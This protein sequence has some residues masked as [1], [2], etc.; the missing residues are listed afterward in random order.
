MNRETFAQTYPGR[1]TEQQY[2][3]LP[4]FLAGLADEAIG[5][6]LYTT[7][8]NIGHH[9]SNICRKFDIL[10]EDDPDYR[11][12]LVKLFIQHK[13]ELVSDLVREKYGYINRPRYP[14]GAE[15]LD[16]PY[17]VKRGVELTCSNAL[18]EVGSL[19]RISVPKEMGKTSLLKRLIAE[20]KHKQFHTTYLN[21]SQFEASALTDDIT[22]LKKF[23]AYAAQ[24]LVDVEASSPWNDSLSAMINCTAQFQNL[25]RQLK[26]NLVLVLDE[27]DALFAYPQVY[28]SFFPMLRNWHND[29]VNDSEI[30]EKLR[31][32]IAYSTEDF[33]R[34][35]INQSPFNVGIPI[36]LQNF[37]QDQVQEL[38]LRHG[39]NWQEILPL[40]DLVQ[41]HPYLIRLGF[42]HLANHTLPLRELLEHAPTDDGI[43]KSHLFRLLDILQTRPDLGIIFQQ[44]LSQAKAVEIRNKTAQLNQLEGMGLI[45]REGNLVKVRSE[46]YR[47]YFRDRIN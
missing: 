28:Q 34:L 29:K 8:S 20:A 23:S 40:H 14:E 2:R 37:T 9:M 47:Q 27:V 18:E 33:G 5:A 41:G 46:L 1:L 36:K 7:R 3:V 24:Q 10:P 13:P 12:S 16:S 35:D 6:Q 45:K 38:A 31:L 15:P 30:W 43:Y 22:F 17:Y 44:L 19:T 4:L 39:L 26:G 11:E 42:Y 21:L 32:I 25:L